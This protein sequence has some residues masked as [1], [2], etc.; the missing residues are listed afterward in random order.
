LQNLS[1]RVQQSGVDVKVLDTYF[2]AAQRPTMDEVLGDRW[3]T[4]AEPIGLSNIPTTA[5][6]Y[7]LGDFYARYVRLRVGT[8]SSNGT[9][10]VVITGNRSQRQ[11]LLN[12][13]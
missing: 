1:F 12:L 4:L 2:Q 7:Q 9:L 3:L 6:A 13:R 8:T 10:K 5:H 11:A